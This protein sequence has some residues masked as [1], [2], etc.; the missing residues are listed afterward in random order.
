MTD[1]DEL[2]DH[3]REALNEARNT[4]LLLRREGFP[5]AVE[6]TIARVEGALEAAA[7]HNYGPAYDSEAAAQTLRD[8]PAG[9]PVLCIR[10]F[11]HDADIGG[12]WSNVRRLTVGKTY[13]KINEPD[14]TF[15][16]A[17]CDEGFE[18]WWPNAEEHFIPS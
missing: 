14:G 17:S 16:I 6:L 8:L 13:N 7:R 5:A 11:V 4:L 2:I 1:A 3:L 15:K 10:E 18:C 12:R 9:S